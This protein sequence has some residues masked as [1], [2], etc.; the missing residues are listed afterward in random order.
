MCIRDSLNGIW[1]PARAA[2]FQ[3]R[4]F[5][6]IGQP[7]PFVSV[8]TFFNKNLNLNGIWAPVRAANFQERNFSPIG[9][10]YPLVSV[11]TFFSKN[12][13]L[14]DIWAPARAANFSGAQ[15]FTDTLNRIPLWALSCF[16]RK[17]FNLN[18]IWPWRGN[19][20]ICCVSVNCGKITQKIS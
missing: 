14:N 12:L 6:P 16:F 18:G 4:N 5:S 15:L 2:I 20:C 10:P 3:E 1:A 9:Q 8:F 7:Y 17:S 13:N 19:H 11:F